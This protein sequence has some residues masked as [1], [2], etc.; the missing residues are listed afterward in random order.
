MSAPHR[1]LYFNSWST[2][3]GGSSTSLLDIVRSLDRRRFDP[4][5]VCPEPGDL[6]NRLADV[7]VPVVIHP[8]SR[9]NREQA[10]Q[11]LGEVF[12]Y[13]RFLRRQDIALVHGNTSSSR[14]SL[15][16]A[17]Y[18][19]GVPYIQHVRNGMGRPLESVGC[20]YARR[21]V[22]NSNQVGTALR[23]EPT[24]AHKTVTIYNA[25]DLAQ[26]DA[27][28]NRRLELG[29]PDAPLSDLSARSYLEKGSGR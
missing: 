2:A 4:L 17:A 10:W 11:F 14:R 23:Q 19:A 25:V 12:W 13:L 24:M 6:P 20:R 18:L 7:G 26:Y 9:L 27:C 16:Q 1:V 21:I 5:V 8:L 3:H 15:L 29:S 22:V 28:D